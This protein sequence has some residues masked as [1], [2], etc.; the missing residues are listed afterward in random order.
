MTL[1]GEHDN[2]RV[3]EAQQ[4]HGAE[5]WHE[6]LL[7]APLADGR[8]QSV[9]GDDACHQRDPQEQQHAP[10]DRPKADVHP[11]GRARAARHHLYM[12]AP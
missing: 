12:R 8:Q 3:D 11:A 6:L 5:V 2:D 7:K 9:A 4:R 10:R 1:Q